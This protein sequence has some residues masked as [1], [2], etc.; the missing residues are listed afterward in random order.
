MW[1]KHGYGGFQS[2]LQV[3]AVIRLVVNEAWAY[4]CIEVEP[5]VWAVVIRPGCGGFWVDIDEGGVFD[6]Q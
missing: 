1:A 4:G 3:V 5:G 6:R 2:W